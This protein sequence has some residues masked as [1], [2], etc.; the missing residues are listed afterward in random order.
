MFFMGEKKIGSFASVSVSSPR[1]SAQL[2]AEDVGFCHCHSAVDSE[3]VPTVTD[4]TC[5]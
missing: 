5:E 4:V 1:S 3:E 2:W